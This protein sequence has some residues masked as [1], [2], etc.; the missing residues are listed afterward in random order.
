MGTW[1]WGCR[2]RLWEEKGE[3]EKG[4]GDKGEEK[5]GEGKGEGREQIVLGQC[6]GIMG[7]WLWVYPVE[8]GE[9][10]VFKSVVD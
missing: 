7:N 2:S 9:H 4:W 1:P 10:V 6:G 5:K 8:F 3:R